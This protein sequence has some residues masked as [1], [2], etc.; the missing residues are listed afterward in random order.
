MYGD[1]KKPLVPLAAVQIASENMQLFRRVFDINLLKKRV[2]KASKSSNVYDIKVPF[3]SRI[4]SK[5]S[6]YR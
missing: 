2:T 6:I 1:W 4:S 3:L 5:T